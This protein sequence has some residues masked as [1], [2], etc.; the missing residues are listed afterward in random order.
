MLY[1]LIAVVSTLCP[2]G[3]YVTCHTNTFSQVRPGNLNEVKE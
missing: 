1:E 2:L 3:H